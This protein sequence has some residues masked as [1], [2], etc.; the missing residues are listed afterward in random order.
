[1]L[2]SV[3]CAECINLGSIRLKGAPTWQPAKEGVQKRKK[4]SPCTPPP[5]PKHNTAYTELEPNAVFV[6]DLLKEHFEHI[7]GTCV[8]FDLHPK[9]FI[10]IYCITV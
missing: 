7:I 4:I 6:H 3:F 9:I 2:A 5:R 1:M 8:L 10:Y